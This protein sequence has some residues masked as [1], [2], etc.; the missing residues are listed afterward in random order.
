MSHLDSQNGQIAI[1]AR[2]TLNGPYGHS[3]VLK[4]GYQD[5]YVN[6]ELPVDVWM[7]P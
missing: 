1:F 3:E 2:K 7:L 4:K 6:G 5:P